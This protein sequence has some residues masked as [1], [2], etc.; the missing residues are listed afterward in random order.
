M[1]KMSSRAGNLCSTNSVLFCLFLIIIILQ[2]RKEIV[3]ET[4][5]V[6]QELLTKMQFEASERFKKYKSKIFFQ[7]AF[8]ADLIFFKYKI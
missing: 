6:R 4:N 5:R 1:P 8:A 7:I 3:E 2:I